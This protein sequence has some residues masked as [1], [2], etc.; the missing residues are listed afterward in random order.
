LQGGV[1]SEVSVWIEGL[2]REAPLL[3]MYIP[4]NVQL[5]DLRNAEQE[6][7]RAREVFGGEGDQCGNSAKGVES[8]GNIH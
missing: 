6:V 7:S 2:Q 3:A 1:E 8:I 4:L 5:V